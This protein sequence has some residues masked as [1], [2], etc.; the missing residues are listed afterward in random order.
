LFERGGIS[1]QSID[2]ALF[3]DRE[4]ASLAA[5]EVRGE[6]LRVFAGERA[7]KVRIKSFAF[8]PLKSP[9]DWFP[10]GLVT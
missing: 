6:T 10:Q 2:P 3:V 8:A 5:V 4:E 7:V 1:E 9:K